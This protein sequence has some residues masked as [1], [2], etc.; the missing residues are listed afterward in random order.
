MHSRAFEFLFLGNSTE[1]QSAAWV[2][3]FFFLALYGLQIELEE[4]EPSLHP[5]TQV[6]VYTLKRRKMCCSSQTA[7]STTRG[8]ARLC[9]TD[10]LCGCQTW[11]YILRIHTILEYLC[12]YKHVWY[13]YCIGRARRHCCSLSNFTGKNTPLSL[14]FSPTQDKC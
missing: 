3:F 11:P 14:Q 9:S 5:L 8:R 7:T 6:I 10:I 2:I 1:K 13:L 4:K 12:K